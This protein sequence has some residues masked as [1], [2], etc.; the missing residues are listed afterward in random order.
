MINLFSF[1]IKDN[2]C[3]QALVSGDSPVALLLYSHLPTAIISLIVGIFLLFKNKKL[4]T[5]I[6]FFLTLAFFIF[7]L[8]DLTEWFAFL[9]RNSIMFARSIIELIDPLLFLLSLYFLYVLVKKKDIHFIYKIIWLLP[10]VP[11]FIMIVQGVNLTGYNWQICEAIENTT[12][13]NYVFYLDIFYL[14]SII[15][16]AITSIILGKNNRKEITVASIGVAV[17]TTIFFTMEYVFTGYILGGVFDYKYFIYAFFG[18]PILI[19]FLAYLIVK[20]K[21]FNIKLIA[22][23]TLVWGLIALIGAQFFFISGITTFVLTGVTFLASV[24]LGDFLIKSV[25][26]EVK[27]KERLQILSDQLQASK[28]RVE[29]SNLK[30]EDAND[31]LKSLDKLKTEFISLATHQLRSPLTSIIGYASMLIEESYGKVAEKQKQPLDRIYQSGR[32]LA[33]VIEDFLNVSK[34]E[35]GGMKYEMVFVDMKKM[36]KDLVSELTLAAKKKGLELSFEEKDLGDYPARAD[37][38]KMRQVLLN[39]I[40]N[41]IKYTQKGFIK[42]ILTKPEKGKIRISITDSGMG[43]SKEIMGTL[44]AKFARGE[45]AKVNTGGSGLGLYLAKEI[46]EAHHGKVWAESPGV[47]LGSSFIIELDEISSMSQASATSAPVTPT[48]PQETATP[49]KKV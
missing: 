3:Y 15:I 42:V 38:T 28:M 10:I 6:F 48:A 35:S 27:Q 36:A 21:T 29:E 47:G 37:E 9:G 5:K 39:L 1:F 49:E 23:Q 31:R 4:E 26:R 24:I 46:V 40:D 22:T 16:F 45:G 8:G 41:S 19:G 17:F 13:T 43:I 2:F 18:M 14:A 33:M 20:Y 44:F 25:Q 34:I 32:N 11:E 7:T 30:L 12:L